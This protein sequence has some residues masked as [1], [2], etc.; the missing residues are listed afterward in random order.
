[1][2]SDFKYRNLV[3]RLLVLG[4]IVF[5]AVSYIP[6]NPLG[7][8]VKLLIS[9]LVVITYSV[10]DIAFDIFTKFKDKMCDVVC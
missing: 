9:L 2:I 1:M 10:I 4:I 6:S 3:L 7:T 5:I 8:E